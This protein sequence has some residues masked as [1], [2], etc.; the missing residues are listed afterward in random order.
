MLKRLVPV[1][2]VLFACSY[3]ALSQVAAKAAN[4]TDSVESVV[5]DVIASAEQHLLRGEACYN[6]GDVTCAR[7]EFDIA[8]DTIVTSGIDVRADRRLSVYWRGMVERID[9]Y[10]RQAFESEAKTGWKL[11][12][13]DGKPPI[14]PAK[15]PVVAEADESTGGPLSVEEFQRRFAKLQ[16]LFHEKYGRDLAITGADHEEHRRLYGEG[17]AIDVR[18]RDLTSEQIGF[19]L[20]T[21][22]RLGLRVKDFSSWE[23]VEVHNSR[24][25]TLGLPSDTLATAVHIHIDRE[26]TGRYV[27]KPA[28]KT[29]K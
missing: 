6:A 19:V 14:D 8:T 5:N 22:R 18:V 26:G 28:V 11:Q 7:R 4:S 27:A 15:D 3:P 13:F 23:K 21:G 17:S 1:L 20:D 12:E 24:V 25:R 10:Q 16:S 2:V 29:G 9:Q